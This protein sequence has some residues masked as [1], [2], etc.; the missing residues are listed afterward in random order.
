MPYERWDVEQIDS[1]RTR[2]LEFDG[3]IVGMN[4]YGYD[5]RVLDRYFA[6]APLI[7]KT[8][9]LQHLLWK[10]GAGR[11]GLGYLAAHNL[12]AQKV[13]GSDMARHWDSG[14]KKF[15]IKRNRVDCELTF[16][17]YEV[18]L[19]T[20]ELKGG[21]RW[22]FSVSEDEPEMVL[23]VAGVMSQFSA[24]EYRWRISNHG[25]VRGDPRFA[26]L[27]Y[28]LHPAYSPEAQSFFF[29][30]QCRKCGRD[31]LVAAATKSGLLSWLRSVKCENCGS[32]YELPSGRMGRMG[33][34][35]RKVLGLM[36]SELGSLQNL[37]GMSEVEVRKYL[38]S[39]V[40][41]KAATRRWMRWHPSLEYWQARASGR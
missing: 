12:K 13:M 40:H 5:Y 14:D 19:R 9:D 21:K 16:S 3:L 18:L 37:Q 11:V 39:M 6:V 32:K 7:T 25:S 31:T 22:D 29:C 28:Y 36:H 41:S 2:L 35:F 10:L 8:L 20:G 34:S 26:G 27:P 30:A 4:L 38:S 17:L 1:L 33:G 23:E 24:S 15:V